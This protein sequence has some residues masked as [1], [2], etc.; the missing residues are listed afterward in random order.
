MKKGD[1]IKGLRES[2]GMTQEELAKILGTTKQTV[3]KYET[4]VITNIPSDKIEA[5]ADTFQT[6]PDF[7]MGWTLTTSSTY[8]PESDKEMLEHFH[9]LNAFGK[10]TAIERVKEMTELSQYVTDLEEKKA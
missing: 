2:F 3:Y 7:V 10:Q 9:K 1:I 4:G 8:T 5:I 6:T